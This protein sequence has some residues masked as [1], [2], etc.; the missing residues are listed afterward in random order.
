MELNSTCQSP[1]VIAAEEIAAAEST[2]YAA[3]SPHP[4]KAQNEWFLFGSEIPIIPMNNDTNDVFTPPS[5]WKD[6]SPNVVKSIQAH[7]YNDLREIFNKH[8]QS[9]IEKGIEE[10]IQAICDDR[11]INLLNTSQN[12][13][14]LHDSSQRVSTEEQKEIREKLHKFNDNYDEFNEKYS[15]FLKKTDK[16][17]TQIQG[18]ESNLAKVKQEVKQLRG[19]LE[20]FRK[21]AE[22]NLTK[23]LHDQLGISTSSIKKRKDQERLTSLE[24]MTAQLSVQLNNYEQRARL[25]NLEFLNI[26]KQGPHEDPYNVIINFLHYHFGIIITTRDISVCHR[27]TIPTDKKRLGRKYIPP[28]YCRF[29]NRSLARMILERSKHELIN[30]VNQY[31]DPLQVRQNLTLINRL[32]WEEVNSKLVSFR[33]KWITNGKI[34]VKKDGKSKPINVISDDIL[35]ELAETY[36]GDG[37][38]NV[39][40]KEKT[41]E[42]NVNRTATQSSSASAQHKSNIP[43]DAYREN[44]NHR[45]LHTYASACTRTPFDINLQIPSYSANSLI[46]QFYSSHPQT[47]RYR[48]N[49]PSVFAP[50]AAAHFSDVRLSSNSSSNRNILSQRFKGTSFR[51]FTS[52]PF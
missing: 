15:M 40:Q 23:E 14:S 9:L 26:P 32:L 52:S 47:S 43:S 30:A 33:Y 45:I 3:K 38:E 1:E 4:A 7:T 21:N 20:S 48:N 39:E 13:A 46:P 44:S 51:N 18:L 16:I 49:H 35:N 6:M 24:K 11:I 31:G 22:E 25:E 36:G 50:S 5:E 41:V 12:N 29:L 8:I 10:K 17:D 34:F 2:P 19:Q 28:I 27:Q 42:N 37:C